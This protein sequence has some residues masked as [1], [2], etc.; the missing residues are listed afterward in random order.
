MVARGCWRAAE[1]GGRVGT[2]QRGGGSSLWAGSCSRDHF[3][4]C[5]ISF[6]NSSSTFQTLSIASHLTY[7]PPRREGTGHVWDRDKSGAPRGDG[8]LVL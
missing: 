6:L 4:A 3:R 2:L 5:F 7:S 8:W 1:A